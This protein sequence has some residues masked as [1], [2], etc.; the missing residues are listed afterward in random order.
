MR[1][2]DLIGAAYDFVANDIAFG[3]RQPSPEPS[4]HPLLRT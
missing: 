1:P 4:V 3:D 2:Y